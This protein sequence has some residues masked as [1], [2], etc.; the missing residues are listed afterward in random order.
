MSREVDE[1]V[2][3]MYFDNKDFEKNAQTTIDTLSQLREG[4]DLEEAAK[5]FDTLKTA[6]NKLELDKVDRKASALKST[7][8]GLGSVASKAFDIGTAPLTSITN[9]FNT[10]KSYTTQMLGFDVGGKIASTIENSVRQ[11]TIEPVSAG[12]SEYELKMDSIKTIMSGSGESLDVVKA[13]LEELNQ[14]ADKT[15]YSFSDMT[16]NIGKFT[17]N[18]VKLDDATAAMKGIA[19]AAADAGQGANEASRAMY[20][21]SQALGVGSMKLVDWKSLEN[22][23]IAT[24]K[25]K[26]TFLQVGAAMGNLKKYTDK[27]GK[28]HYFDKDTKVDAKKVSK[29]AGSELEAYLTGL[30]KKTKNKAEEIT[31]ENFRESLKSDWLDKDAMLR[32]FQIYGGDDLDIDTLQSWGFSEEEAIELQKIGQEAAK[33][34][35]E[36]RTFSKMWDALKEAAQS[37][38][39]QSMEYVFGDMEE[40][41]KLWTDLNETISGV[42]NKNADDRNNALLA[43]R[44]M[45]K[46]ENGELHKIDE[47]ADEY[48][49]MNPEKI[50]EAEDG[51]ETLINSFKTL[52]GVIGD[53]GSVAGEA[54][55]SVFG[56]LD[57]KKLL[58]ITHKFRDFVDG[59]RAW[60]DESDESGSRLDKIKRGLTGLFS[61]LKTIVNFVKIGFNL[62]SR[63]VKP[64]AN[65]LTDLFASLG[66]FFTGMGE[67]S[68]D[69]V[70]VKLG[71]GIEILWTKLKSLFSVGEDGTT[72]IST[73]LSNLWTDLKRV[74]R[75][76]ANENGLGGTLDA[77]KS[78]WSSITGW[79]GWTDIAN[80]FNT[81]KSAVET[82]WTTVSSWEGWSE[83]GQFFTDS[84]NW[85]K[86]KVTAKKEYD[87]KGFELNT[88]APIVTWL[89]DIWSSVESIW[90]TLTEW[91]GWTDIGNF[92]TDCYS[93]VVGL[94]T[95]EKKYD[96]KGFE[97]NTD[98]PIVAWLKGVWDAVAE[99]WDA[100]AKWESWEAI[101]SFFTDVW[102]WISSQ[103]AGKKQYDDRGFEM[104]EAE[105]SPVVA[106]LK[107]IW[108]A[109][110]EVWDS[111][112]EWEGWKAIGSFFVNA[113]GW[114]TSQ[115]KEKKYDDKGF[116]LNEPEDSPVVKWLKG[117]WDAVK[118]VWETIVEWDGW[119]AIGQFFS[120][121]IGWI[122]SQFKEKK[123]DDR[124]FELSEPEEAPIVKWLNGILEQVQSAW[125]GIT[126]WEGWQSIG[127]F[128]TDIFGWVSGLFSAK[129]G[130]QSEGS[131]V[132]VEELIPD[133]AKVGIIERIVEVLSGL[134]DKMTA[135]SQSVTTDPTVA[136]IWQ[137]INDTFAVILELIS[138]VTST[139]KK[140]VV[141]KDLLSIV[142]TGVTVLATLFAKFWLLNKTTKKA[143]ALATV[144]ENTQSFGMQL[145]EIAGAIA[146][147]VTAV[148][149]LTALESGKV[150]EAI[151]QIAVIAAL[152]SALII[153]INKTQS[154]LD[155][156]ERAKE[157]G[158]E[159]LGQSLIKWAGI[160]GTVA[161]VM[162]SLPALIQAI[163]ESKKEGIGSDILATLTGAMEV[164]GGAM[165]AFAVMQK[166]APKGIDPVATVKSV[167]SVMAGV[168]IALA[169]MIGA[170]GLMDTLSK[171]I[172]DTTGYGG[173]YIKTAVGWINDMGELFGA[174]G[175]AIGR[176]FG[177]LVGGVVGGYNTA[178]QN[179]KQRSMESQLEWLG[180]IANKL[181]PTSLTKVGSIATMISKISNAELDATQLQILTT[182]LPELGSALQQF[183][184][185]VNA[186]ES[187]R[188]LDEGWFQRSLESIQIV[189]AFADAMVALNDAFMIYSSGMNL[190]GDDMSDM[191]ETYS[192]AAG[193]LAKAIQEGLGENGSLTF[194]ASPI[195]DSIVIALGL[196]ETAIAT[197]VHNMVQEGMNLSG[198]NGYEPPQEE[199]TVDTSTA[200]FINGLSGL[201]NGSTLDYSG[202][203][204]QITGE[205][206]MVAQITA[207]LDT[208]PNMN[209]LLSD[210]GYTFTDEEGN[211]IDIV[212]ELAGQ[213]TELQTAVD[214]LP[215]FEI[216]ITPVFDMTGLNTESLQSQINAQTAGLT[217]NIPGMSVQVDNTAMVN[218]QRTTN[219]QLATLNSRISSLSAITA[220][221]IS[222][223]SGHMDGIAES[224]AGLKLYLDSETLV[225]AIAGKLNYAIGAQTITYLRTGV[226]PKW[227][228][229]QTNGFD[230]AAHQ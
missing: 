178:E 49:M 118:G 205:G 31:A 133:E 12:W 53:L 210:K 59:I 110:K 194:D 99:V 71:A 30:Q 188:A 121:T 225:G 222:G 60:L 197:A 92:L 216:K 65:V 57:G 38:W 214:A 219:S 54:W 163:S 37:G 88:E 85:V 129:E 100:F 145:L 130:D 213:M 185:N 204:D 122:T 207:G 111:I 158:W 182:E 78:V 227:S 29:L 24:T 143:T 127:Q 192:K 19:N 125:N 72:P 80:A 154:P 174:L 62:V 126:G 173:D 7:L 203:V 208:L 112:S 73:W 201:M 25:L 179:E 146:L 105:D 108:E 27:D 221:S 148:A 18:G 150:W 160:M 184:V 114:I 90:G 147:I 161:I 136:K 33:A 123:Y 28:I 10:I 187:G 218:Q 98:A 14:Y 199:T 52:I 102:G 113:W 120:N 86:D 209:D 141:D 159:R 74:V 15:V 215:A 41:T 40:A 1:R 5:G 228:T 167:A 69:E 226:V 61:V 151:G 103:F 32:T 157:T 3:A 4:M 82:A 131:E 230:L 89:K 152:M 104:T 128:M 119:N 186:L 176:L 165:I 198:Q 55:T 181:D 149:T 172:K 76:W 36:V 91:S 26:D 11:L 94:V 6:A 139:L 21:I 84:W 220:S 46:D 134:W 77:V 164:I 2:V 64:V 124:G 132:K 16:S 137:N 70:F 81:A 106:W 109:V 101:G 229:A 43:W 138:M 95:A 212:S 162:N 17:N 44:G 96:D 8:S 107:S 23:N 153:A 51:R 183:M 168:A 166:I 190:S 180:K 200:E 155:E 217:M 202:I 193:Q 48:W 169:A 115:F 39:A 35:T 22:A 117:I 156:L 63:L 223:L 93:W 142:I 224:V 135:F 211:T 34:A 42:L 13:K 75:E 170:G 56:K 83:I 140:A 144:S 177:G 97:M 50:Q 9:L 45:F 66:D 20:N 196:G 58:D 175:E 116:E 189:Q 206:G 79:Q 68:P 171:I 191:L 195:I 67:L 47:E 87:E